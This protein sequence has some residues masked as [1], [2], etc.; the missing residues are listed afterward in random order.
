MIH[1][2]PRSVLA[3][4]TTLAVLSAAA[5]IWTKSGNATATSGK[6]SATKG[7][8]DVE[9]LIEE[10]N[11]QPARET[12]AP[13]LE[14]ICGTA[15]TGS[16]INASQLKVS[17]ALANFVT[18][19]EFAAVCM[20]PPVPLRRIF[21]IALT[22]AGEV[23][24]DFVHHILTI[25]EQNASHELTTDADLEG[26]E[27]VFDQ[28][29][30]ALVTLGD[31]ADPTPAQLMMAKLVTK[32]ASHMPFD[33]WKVAMDRL[34]LTLE[35]LMRT[36][37]AL[38]VRESSALLRNLGVV[39]LEFA[40][41]RFGREWV[42]FVSKDLDGFLS[43]V[44]TAWSPDLDME[45]AV[46]VLVMAHAFDGTFANRAVAS[47]SFAL[48]LRPQLREKSETISFMSDFFA[49]AGRDAKLTEILHG[50]PEF[51]DQLLRASIEKTEQQCTTL[52]EFHYPDLDRTQDMIDR[53]QVLVNDEDWPEDGTQICELLGA[54]PGE[55][56]GLGD[57]MAKF[58][59]F[60]ANGNL[61]TVM[62][63]FIIEYPELLMTS[64]AA[65]IIS[66]IADATPD[67]APNYLRLTVVPMFARMRMALDDARTDLRQVMSTLYRNETPDDDDLERT[68]TKFDRAQ[69]VMVYAAV[70]GLDPCAR[71]MLEEMPEC[72][73]TLDDLAEIVEE[74][75]LAFVT[76]EEG[77]AFS[78]INMNNATQILSNRT[79]KAQSGNPD[80]YG[81]YVELAGVQTEKNVILG[82][83]HPAAL[84]AQTLMCFDKYR[85]RMIKALVPMMIGISS[86][87]WVSLIDQVLQ[88]LFLAPLSDPNIRVEL[89]DGFEYASNLLFMSNDRFDQLTTFI[90][91][92]VREAAYIEMHRIA[93][94]SDAMSPVQWNESS[95]PDLFY[96]G[97]YG[98]RILNR[99]LAVA[100]TRASHGATGRG[101]IGYWLRTDRTLYVIPGFS[102][103]KFDINKFPVGVDGEKARE[104]H[105]WYAMGMTNGLPVPDIKPN[106]GPELHWVAVLLDLDEGT[107]SICRPGTVAV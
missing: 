27:G 1:E 22:P 12:L 106:A 100:M 68:V 52:L 42:D 30:T 41:F 3:T 74:L 82:A 32:C 70:F 25:V 63:R 95:S 17:E 28:L 18:E 103:R 34:G 51:K 66:G 86:F 90:K 67:L 53:L 10:F 50:I 55:I 35:Q 47:P 61:A 64:T 99:S 65:L 107:M 84:T 96:S 5:Y 37:D 91:A 16:E 4:L 93:Q 40:A 15:V 92:G 72:R 24:T 78:L 57:P 76:D 104:Q 45:R 79:G 54:I 9:K 71:R 83:L 13:L 26:D 62:Q 58:M 29:L 56:M 77:K 97:V 80:L 20:L 75:V 49:S 36:A 2:V 23:S 102:T 89:R 94:G 38:L 59:K 7:E 101:K 60:N 46:R 73:E 31:T 14:L 21:H 11:E 44:F 98:N 43:R 39:I 69:P 8:V 105:E 6:R 88:L 87:S 33:A 85:A 19:Y 81:K 48:A